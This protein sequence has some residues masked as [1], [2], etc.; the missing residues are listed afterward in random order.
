LE[1]QGLNPI[2]IDTDAFCKLEIADLLDEALSLLG[3]DRA[4]CSRLAALPF[5]LGRGRLRN[6]LGNEIADVLAARAVR[7]PVI[8]TAS[9]LWLDKLTRISA[10]DPGEALLFAA[11]AEKQIHVITADKR[12]LQA[13]KSV[14]EF[15]EPMKGRIVLLEAVLNGLCQAQGVEV[16]RRRV[17]PLKRHDKVIEIAFSAG[18]SDPMGALNSYLG[19]AASKCSPIELWKADAGGSK[20]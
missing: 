10:I 20:A 13:L 6:L 14:P 17:E 4:H 3:S 2:L 19:D 18:N 11:G 16:V 7:L 9:P 1:I 12:A 5:M 8:A 15:A